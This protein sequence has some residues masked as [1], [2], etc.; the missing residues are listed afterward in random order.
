MHPTDNGWI[1]Y[2]PADDPDAPIP[3]VFSKGYGNLGFNLFLPASISTEEEFHKH[4]KQTI[5]FQGL[6]DILVAT[7]FFGSYL[8]EI[9]NAQKKKMNS[10]LSSMGHSSDQTQKSSCLKSVCIFLKQPAV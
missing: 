4:Q 7:D 8:K 10:I 1:S 5:V 9:F 6:N 2:S 3:H